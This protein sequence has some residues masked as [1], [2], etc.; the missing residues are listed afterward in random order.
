MVEKFLYRIPN[1]HG[2]FDEIKIKNRRR[3]FRRTSGLNDDEE[4]APVPTAV[5]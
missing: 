3:R 1:K 4:P 5:N 2:K